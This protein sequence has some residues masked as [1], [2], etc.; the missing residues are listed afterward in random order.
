MKGNKTL[1]PVQFV[2]FFLQRVALGVLLVSFGFAIEVGEY[3]LGPDVYQWLKVLEM[4]VSI[5]VVVLIL[6]AF[7]RYVWYRR[8]HGRDFAPEGYVS[9]MFRRSCARSFEVTFI[10]LLVV[11]VLAHRVFET[12]PAKIFLD[13]TLFVTLAVMSLMFLRL[14][15]STDDDDDFGGEAEQ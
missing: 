5:G 10:F 2:D 14:N 7:V 3:L 6:P 1:T 11:E 8:T 15:R 9:E 4:G 13:A 12:V